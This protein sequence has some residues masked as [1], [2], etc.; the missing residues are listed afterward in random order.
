M[1]ESRQNG[2][3]SQFFLLKPVIR[4]K[5]IH[6]PS[7]TCLLT[8]NF[9]MIIERGVVQRLLHFLHSATFAPIFS[10]S[11]F[12]KYTDHYGCTK[13]N[14]RTCPV[15]V[16]SPRIAVRTAVLREFF[17][18]FRCRLG[19]MRG[20]NSSSGNQMGFFYL[21]PSR[22]SPVRLRGPDKYFQ[23]SETVIFGILET[24]DPL[25]ARFENLSHAT[26]A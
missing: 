17:W 15:S 6:V 22:E 24:F 5:T 7:G 2:N 8:R 1:K 10:R 3:E 18:C 25:L 23:Q 4:S 11:H 13:Q 9:H 26:A 21:D 16:I 19:C 14:Q 20:R 12:P